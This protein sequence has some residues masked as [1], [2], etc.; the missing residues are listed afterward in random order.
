MKTKFYFFGPPRIEQAGELL[1]L[2]LQKAL[3]L[4]S[5]L[6]VS[7]QPHTREALATLLWP[8]HDQ[9]AGRGRLRR[10]LYELNN[11]L[12]SDILHVSSDIIGLNPNADVWTD[13]GAFRQMVGDTLPGNASGVRLPDEAVA[14]LNE[15]A[16]LYTDD[17]LGGF[18]LPDAPDFEEW[19][20]FE[21]EDLR[22]SLAEALVQLAGAYQQRQEWE[23]AIHFG[24]RWLA[25]DA[26]HE[27]AHRL[28]MR[29]FA[30]SGHV[31]AAVRQYEQCVQ[32][33]EEELGT[34]PE[35][36]TTALY[37]AIRTRRFTPEPAPTA[38]AARDS[39]ADLS[40]SDRRYARH[41]KVFAG[42]HAEVFRGEDLSNG[43]VVAIKR[44]NARLVSSD[45]ELVTRFIREGELLRQLNHPNIIRIL[46]VME[47]DGQQ[48]IVMEYVGGGSLRD[49]LD[50][51]GAL[52]PARALD[53]AL[54][55]ADALVLAHESGI[56][57]RDLKPDNVLL[58]T[59][60]T[61]RLTDF[62]LARLMHSN[63]RLTQHGA[64]LGTLAYMSPEAINGETLDA[65]SDIW[66]FGVM[67][68][69]MLAGER[70]FRAEPISSLLS[71]ILYGPLPDLHQERPE[72]P[73]SLA[74]LLK[75]VL[76]R[77]RDRR[78][79]SMRRLAAILEA[80]REGRP[81][82]SLLEVA[83]PVAA[84]AGSEAGAARTAPVLPHRLPARATPFIGR[85]KEMAAI[86][87][88][89]A[90]PQVR[91]LTILGPGGMGKTRLALAAARQLLEQDPPPAALDGGLYFVPLAPLDRADKIVQA[92]ADALNLS[93]EANAP[94]SRT[95]QWQ[96][97]DFLRE[98][99]L[100]LILDNF[101]HLPEGIPLVGDMLRAAPGLKIIVT[102]RE[103]LN[104]QDEHRLTLSG[105]DYPRDAQGQEGTRSIG[106]YAAVKLFAQSA[107]R[108][109][110]GFV[111]AD[112]NAATVAEIC[113]LVEGMPLAV[114]LTAA[115]LDVL[116]VA[117][118]A[119]EVQ[120]NLDFL[121]TDKHDVPHR[122]RSIRAVFETTWQR[123]EAS[124]Q[125]AFE[126]LSVF[127]GGFDRIAAV[128][129]SG[130]TLRMLR[131][132]VGKSLLQY[133]AVDDRYQMHELLRQY[134]VQKLEETGQADEVRDQHSAYF[135]SALQRY[136]REIEG[137]NKR[138]ALAA[139]ERDIDNV[140]AAW[141]WAVAQGQIRRL[142]QAMH[143]LEHFFYWRSR[144]HEAEAFYGKA[145]E[146]V[147]HM[148]PSPPSDETEHRRMVAA[149]QARHANFDY[150]L[151]NWDAARREF[152]ASLQIYE[153]LEK[154]MACD[155]RQEKAYILMKMA[156]VTDDLQEARRQFE[157][158]L[159]LY[160]TVGHRWWAAGLRCHLG[161]VALAS[162]NYD[163]ARRWFEDSLAL[164]RQLGDQW[165]FGWVM[166]GLSNVALYQQ[167]FDEAETLAQESLALHREI[168]LRD[169][170]A[171][172]LTT[173]CWISL[174]RGEQE[175]ANQYREEAIA[176]WQDL[177][178][179]DRINV[180]LGLEDQP[181][182][183]R[184]FG[185]IIDMRIGAIF[186]Q[187]D[188]K[189]DG[190]NQGT[191]STS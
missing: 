77:E 28:L 46:D 156:D 78:L 168:G 116:P 72:I 186:K 57:H 155:V 43:E 101:E 36:E 180:P 136:Q 177:G 184:W 60:G 103:R 35:E 86:A 124:E 148:P 85:D 9:S 130:I 88:F 165:Q 119:Q 79:P 163:E 62:G 91:L 21:A 81:V 42:G 74:L 188:R 87:S 8:E 144:I 15:A 132:L 29:L 108:T 26:L 143:S 173:L 189:A 80:I 32:V 170:I 69:E 1:P 82:H 134:G 161:Y 158:S 66:S 34:E 41:E 140:F 191:E 142:D 106:E 178:L 24:R 164:Y 56:I 122:Q 152:Q 3:A 99:Q 135:C 97:L 12:A 95:P 162:R 172:N 64:F 127:R 23:Q 129:I 133:E 151:Q 20:F 113:R 110:P 73:A 47:D 27:P 89:L 18:S 147:A 104:L 4:L 121:E 30:S 44:L 139:I 93:F 153:E 16:D 94:A 114:E 61:P 55:L 76:V 112:E 137:N 166:D 167:Q 75:Q 141:K 176:I 115:W 10:T 131:H 190:G 125:D 2:K 159:A 83:A 169:R 51:E 107:R 19:R 138:P 157:Q 68:Y 50:A 111:L 17:F 105:L 117:E 145:A 49:L 100:L 63:V 179:E 146:Y 120:R 149:L 39:V 84:A 102:S 181:F 160:E 25:L 59:D 123:L 38:A 48:S 54:P 67:L 154:E 128:Q 11:A 150:L 187:P 174:A 183:P 182:T 71:S 53:I 175:A 13:V 6:V 109:Q 7:G 33:L 52:A 70:P 37:E 98:Q 65:R 96:M 90:D 185:D 118:I 92:I 14:R 5:Y 58:A 40:A 22:Q 45:P 171:D 126:R 31:A